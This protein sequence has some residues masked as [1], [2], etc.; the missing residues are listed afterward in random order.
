M[1]DQVTEY[2]PPTP[3]WWLCELDDKSLVYV[4]AVTRPEA[5]TECNKSFPGQVKAVMPM[6]DTLGVGYGIDP[7]A[8]RRS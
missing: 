2:V 5:W 6:T 8:S 1:I 3:T 7:S 4:R